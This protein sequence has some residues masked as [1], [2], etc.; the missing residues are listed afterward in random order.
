MNSLTSKKSDTVLT[1]QAAAAAAPLSIASCSVSAQ[2]TN[3]NSATWSFT[4]LPTGS[5]F[6][7]SS[8]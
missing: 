6:L 1:Y 4:N 8:R 3:V 2:W 5:Q 7:I